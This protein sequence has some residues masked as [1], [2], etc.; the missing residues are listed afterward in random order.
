MKKSILQKWNEKY[1][2]KI[3]YICIDA[4]KYTV[5]SENNVYFMFD[6]F[7]DEKLKKILNKITNQKLSKNFIIAFNPSKII[8]KNSKLK[9]IKT[10]FRNTYSGKIFKIK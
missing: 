5:N 2:C 8:S 3:E 10:I 4:E 7:P 6:P 9:L 1:K